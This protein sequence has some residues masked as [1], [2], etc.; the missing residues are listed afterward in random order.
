L[1][2]GLASLTSLMSCC[3]ALP[4][5]SFRA[6]LLLL[7]NFITAFMLHCSRM[8]MFFILPNLVLLR[9]ALRVF[10]SVFFKSCF[11]L[12]VSALVCYAKKI[13]IIH[14]PIKVFYFTYN[15]MFKWIYTLLTIMQYNL[16]T[17]ISLNKLN[18]YSKNY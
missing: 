6:F 10:I 9:M 17:I 14:I 4:T 15:I 13:S 5:C 18:C 3:S 7:T 8:S 1:E 11:V 12:V 16:T 2:F